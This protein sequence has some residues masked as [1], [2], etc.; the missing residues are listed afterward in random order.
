MLR[1]GPGELPGHARLDALQQKM[2]GHQRRR[3]DQHAAE[4][5]GGQLGD[6]HGDR[7]QDGRT[8]EQRN[9]SLDRVGKVEKGVHGVKLVER[10]LR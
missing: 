10:L 5:N 1:D 7:A 3:E 6:E 9:E 2:V 8:Q 4:H